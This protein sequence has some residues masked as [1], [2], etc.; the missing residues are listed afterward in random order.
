VTED[1]EDEAPEQELARPWSWVR[2][3]GIVANYAANGCRAAWAF[4]D[5]VK[6]MAV[7]H[8]NVSDEQRVLY[9][10]MHRDLETLPV[11]E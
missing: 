5:D 2:F 8:A 4:F 3:G 6:D 7:A 1:E 9:E 11:N 10:A